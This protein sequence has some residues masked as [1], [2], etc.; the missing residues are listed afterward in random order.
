MQEYNFNEEEFNRQWAADYS[1]AP[2]VK[3]YLKNICKAIADIPHPDFEDIVNFSGFA[4]WTG[5]WF[6]LYCI[7]GGY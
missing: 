5:I 1:S 6:L 4:L 2:T 3:D 7:F